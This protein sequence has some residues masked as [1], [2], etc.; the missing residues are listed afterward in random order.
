M[1]VHIN[2]TPQ[3]KIVLIRGIVI[4]MAEKLRMVTYAVV[5]V[6]R[7]ADAKC[8]VMQHVLLGEL[9]MRGRYGL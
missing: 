2:M 8:V 4:Y 3:K 7:A 9:R 6:G 5:R 1:P